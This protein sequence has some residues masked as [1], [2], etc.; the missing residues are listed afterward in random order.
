M[1]TNTRP[2]Q[3]T[4]VCHCLTEPSQHCPTFILKVSSRRIS[5]GGS[6]YRCTTRVA[7]VLRQ[8]RGK[9]W[10]PA[11]CRGEIFAL[12]G[13][14]FSREDTLQ[15]QEG[16]TYQRSHLPH[17]QA[18]LNLKGK[19]H[20]WFKNWPCIFQEGHAPLQH[21]DNNNRPGAH[22]KHWQSLAR[23]LV[24]Q[25]SQDV[26]RPHIHP[27]HKRSMVWYLCLPWNYVCRFCH[28]FDPKWGHDALCRRK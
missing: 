1:A 19:V 4:L 26:R 17:P 3:F 13:A 7:T 21:E 2:W 9:S 12:H 15:E 16:Q 24:S 14:P 8:E 11:Q 25:V 5:T 22:A 10:G 23:L 28:V 6:S 18:G 27:A 20:G